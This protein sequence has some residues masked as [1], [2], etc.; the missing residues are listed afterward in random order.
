MPRRSVAIVTA[1]FPPDASAGTHRVLRLVRGL[2]SRGWEVVVL[3]LRPDAYRP[4]T[5]RDER[6][7]QSVPEGV[8]VVRT[9]AVRWLE[10]ALRNSKGVRAGTQSAASGRVPAGAARSGG[11]AGDRRGGLQDLKDLLTDAFSLPDASVGWYWP[12]IARGLPALLEHPVRVIVSSA[13]PFTCHLIA[14]RLKRRLGARWVA[15]FRDP[16][17]RAPWALEER[18]TSWRGFVHRTLERRTVERADRVVLNTHRMRDE[19]AAFYGARLDGKFSTITNGFDRH[20]VEPFR[21]PLPPV[22]DGLRLIHAGT[23]YRERDPRPFLRALS[24]LRR[25]GR[26]PPRAILVTFLG[27]ISAGFRVPPVIAELGLED[28]V[29]LVPPVGHAES[30]ARLAASHVLLVVQPGTDLQVPVKLYEYMALSRPI[31]ALAPPGAVSDLVAQGNL[32]LVAA[33]EDEDAI[34]RCLIEFHAH[35]RRL[36]ER[37]QPRDGFVEQFE[38][39]V[40]MAQFETLLAQVADT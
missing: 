3:T 18:T 39:D 31:F 20:V 2:S 16:W 12:A 6:L 9:G 24:S 33:A 26:V 11:G 29:T 5:R 38:A 21:T 23:L 7:L 40:T 25:D 35:A 37:F 15:D 22:D 1:H 17:S 27:G 28:V 19:F 10:R 32:G 34:A 8:T 4:G 13:P 36:E 30:L 14:A